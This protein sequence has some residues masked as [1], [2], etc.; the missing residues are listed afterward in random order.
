MPFVKI[1]YM[2]NTYNCRFSPITMLSEW[3]QKKQQKDFQ[4]QNQKN[5]NFMAFIRIIRVHCTER[6]LEDNI[7][8][9]ICSFILCYYL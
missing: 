4:R 6:E 1:I 5:R 8:T 3:R 2:Y 9:F 7:S